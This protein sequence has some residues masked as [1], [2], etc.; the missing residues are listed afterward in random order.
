MLS[1]ACPRTRS[2]PALAVAVLAAAT[3]LPLTGCRDSE[4]DARMQAQQTI[5]QAA[6]AFRTALAQ[7]TGTNAEE[8]A[9]ELDRVAGTLS[10]I[11]GASPE[12]QAAASLLAA[13]ASSAA[14]RLQLVQANDAA[15]LLEQTRV[16]AAKAGEAA[17]ALEALA[18]VQAKISLSGDRRMLEEQRAAAEAALKDLR[19]QARSVEGPIGELQQGLIQRKDQ[20]SALQT[21]AEQLRRQANDAG[22]SEGFPL[23]VES[24]DV[25]A[26]ARGVRS[27]AAKDELALSTLQ[28]ELTLANSSIV[29]AQSVASAADAAMGDLEN[30]AAAMGS[31]AGATRKTAEELRSRVAAMLTQIGADQETL[32]AAYAAIAAG[33]QKASTSAGR[34][35]SSTREFSAAAKEAALGAKAA[36]ASL[37]A[38]HAGTISSQKQLLEKLAASGTLFGGDSQ[39]AQSAIKALSASYDELVAQAKEQYTA[40]RD[41]LASMGEDQPAVTRM[42]AA[43]ESS[44]ALLEGRTAAPTPAGATAAPTGGSTAPIVSGGG[45]ASPEEYIA[46][47]SAPSFD[48]AYLQRMTRSFRATTPDG[49]QMM[50][51]TLSSIEDLAPMLEAAVKKFG[52]EGLAQLGAGAGA[53]GGRFSPAGGSARLVSKDENRAV[54]AIA[55]GGAGGAEQNVTLVADSGVWFVDADA[56]VESLTAEQ[57]QAMAG[58]G[59]MMAAMRPVM[60]Q[61]GAIVAAKINSGEISSIDQLG[62]AIQQA[63]AAAMGGAD[64]AAGSDDSK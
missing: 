7:R 3:L 45:F 14:A 21:R 30:Y 29:G 15:S 28:P 39:E 54:V 13:S 47:V 20:L 57:R 59:E 25:K 50:Q 33:F 5:D 61:I 55:T 2:V 23:V 35:Q 32:N 4:V 1:S 49:K 18:D 64:G 9:R 63:S 44:L 34:V 46:F 10:S 56:M 38:Q 6:L 27:A 16:L 41:S 26:E 19:E 60:R 58:L 22:A 40:V 53:L 43:I 12:Q 48:A 24:A 37:Y 11:Q 17:A 31:E 36:L 8:T 51:F 42:K 52:A 62:P